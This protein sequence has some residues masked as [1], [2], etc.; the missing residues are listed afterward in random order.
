MSIYCIKTS[1]KKPNLNTVIIIIF[2]VGTCAEI[3]RWSEIVYFLMHSKISIN[4]FRIC[5]VNVCNIYICGR[6]N[7]ARTIRTTV[8]V[9]FGYI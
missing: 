2:I 9:A 5:S 1:D 6:N 3:I 4:T 8:F 7:N